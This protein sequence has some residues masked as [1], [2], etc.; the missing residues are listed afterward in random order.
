MLGLGKALTIFAAL[1]LAAPASLA[2]ADTADTV[3]FNG[4]ILTVDKDFSVQQA[5][6]IGPGQENQIGADDGRR[7]CRLRRSAI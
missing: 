1:Y 2:F 6:A 7:Q 5:L 4:N 3:L